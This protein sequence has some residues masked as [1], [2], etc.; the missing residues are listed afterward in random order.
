VIPGEQVR[1]R[2]ASVAGDADGDPVEGEADGFL[3]LE[4]QGRPPGFGGADRDEE[5]HGYLLRVFQAGTET[6]HCLSSHGCRFRQGASFPGASVYGLCSQ[7]LSDVLR[8]ARP[9]QQE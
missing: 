1:Q 8:M 7:L 3:G 2:W 6:N 4:H 5:G 9:V